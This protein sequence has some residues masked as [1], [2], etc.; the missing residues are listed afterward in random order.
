MVDCVHKHKRWTRNNE[1]IDSTDRHEIRWRPICDH[2]AKSM[3]NI[4]TADNE[5]RSGRNQ[6]TVVCCSPKH[7]QDSIVIFVKR[8]VCCLSFSFV[9]ICDWMTVIVDRTHTIVPLI[10][11][12]EV[13]LINGSL[14]NLLLQK[15]LALTIQMHRNRLNHPQRSTPFEEKYHDKHC[16]HQHPST[17]RSILNWW[18][19]LNGSETASTLR[20]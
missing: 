9:I 5:L 13:T 19:T 14:E 10:Q 18:R 1:S 20:C 7:F 16:K 15:R 2:L 4:L 11:T 3:E 17:D 8:C 6:G 12:P